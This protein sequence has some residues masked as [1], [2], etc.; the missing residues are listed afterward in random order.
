[1]TLRRAPLIRLSAWLAGFGIAVVLALYLARLPL[2]AAAIAAALRSAGAGEVRLA[3]TESSPWQ[4]VVENLDFRYKTQRFEARRVTM[5]RA[6]WW[7]PTLGAVAI[8]GAK[9]PVTIDGSDTNPWSWTTYA[10]TP[11]A[12]SGALEVPAERVT[13]DGVVVV[14]AGGLPDQALSVSFEAG[15]QPGNVWSGRATARG[16]GLQVEADLSYDLGREVL[17]YRVE[18]A[19]LDLK[20]WEGFVQRLTLLPGGF[21]GL[22]GRLSGEAAGRYAGGAL[23]AA[24]KVSLRDGRFE[25]KERKVAARGVEADFEFMDFPKVVSKPGSVRVAELDY[26][27][28]RVTELEAGLEL[29][30][31]EHIQV[32]RASLRAMGGKLSAEPFRLALSGQELEATLLADGID[33]EQVLALAP[34]VPAKAV[35]R[36]DGRLPVRIDSAGLRLGTGW[37]ALKPGVRAEVQFNA[38]GL[39]TG[40]V[41]ANNPTYAILN[42]IETGLLRLK[43]GELRLEIRP[44][45]APAGRSARLHI[46]GEPVDPGVKA[47]VTLDLNVNGPIEQLLNLGM[48]QKVSFGSAK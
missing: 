26:T 46:A 37:L 11:A 36:V 33:V 1:M 41:A 12:G 34:D 45:D 6:R 44:P 5:E 42:K 3:V 21:W 27:D 19:S 29:Q 9:V 4:V 24:G 17:E 14:K 35:G 20:P 25:L 38:K 7:S 2:T 30:G 18:R 32:H 10:P 16:P 22:E 47:P 23:T 31:L 15:Q 43:V 28:L 13:L 8:S 48:N 40:G 39:L